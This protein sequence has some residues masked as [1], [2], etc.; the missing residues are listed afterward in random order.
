M[1]LNYPREELGDAVVTGDDGDWW[2]GVVNWGQQHGLG[3]Q[4]AAKK[5]SNGRD[6][7]LMVWERLD[8]ELGKGTGRFG[9]KELLGCG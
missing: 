6:G 8:F 2:S 9:E 5:G 1:V 4:L 3:Q 7:R